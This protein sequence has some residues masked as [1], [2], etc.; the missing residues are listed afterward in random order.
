MGILKL[1]TIN[2]GWT[3]DTL[4]LGIVRVRYA[5]PF[6]VLLFRYRNHIPQYIGRVLPVAPL[7]LLAVVLF[8]QEHLALDIAL[9][10]VGARLLIAVGFRSTAGRRYG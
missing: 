3:W 5:F 7:T 2:F 4:P 10:V 9:L 8:G 1:G 6:G